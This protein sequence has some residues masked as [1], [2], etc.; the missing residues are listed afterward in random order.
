MFFGTIK[1]RTVCHHISWAFV[2]DMANSANFWV[3]FLFSKFGLPFLG[4]K[5]GVLA[6]EIFSSIADEIGLMFSPLPC[7][8]NIHKCFASSNINYLLC[9]F[10]KDFRPCL[11]CISFCFSRTK[12]FCVYFTIFDITSGL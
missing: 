8:N 4:V 1:Q 5:W 3:Y 6:C 11:V 12:C 2:F 10:N 9:F 7:R